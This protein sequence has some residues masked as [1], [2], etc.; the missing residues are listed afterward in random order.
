MNMTIGFI[1]AGN[2]ASAIINGLIEKT[3]VDPSKIIVSDPSIE[4]LESLKS[5]YNFNITTDNLEVAKKSNI[6]FLCVKPNIYK[7]ILDQISSTL[8]KETIIVTIAAGI[9]LDFIQKNSFNQIKV[10]RTMPNTPALV[11][12][13]VTCMTCNKNISKEESLLIKNLLSSFSKVYEIDEKLMDAVPSVTGSSPA[14]VYMFIEA[15]ADGAVRDGFPRDMAYEMAAQAVLGSAKMVIDTKEHPS[16]LKDRVCSPGG[17][18]IDA[19]IK[20]ESTGFRA[21]ILSAMEACTQK[22]KKMNS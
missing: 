21:S 20:L 14:Y 13:G 7:N 19:V 22:S 16:I 18:T 10:V 12:E 2:M 15:L 6:L 4:K 3:K 1:G 17:T 5:S 8:N 11:G 9:S